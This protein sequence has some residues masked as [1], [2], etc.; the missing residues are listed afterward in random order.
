MGIP[1]LW[2][3]V[4][5]TAQ[6]MSFADLC[7]I[8]GFIQQT[9]STG[10]IIIGVDAGLW[11]AQSQSVFHKPQHSQMGQNPELRVLFYKLGA[12]N[13]VGCQALFVFDGPERP[14]VKR[15]KQVKAK[16]H[17]LV[18]E[19][20]Q[21]IELFGFHHHTA[22]G[23]ADAELAYLNRFGHIDAILSDDSDVTLF[24]GGRII[25]R[26]NRDE[27][28]VYTA[29]ALETGM[30]LTQGGLLLI[31]LF[32]GGD[33]NP[34]GIIGC[35][36]K[37]AYALARCGFGDALLASC[38]NDSVEDL[39]HFLVEWRKQVRTE[40][41]T[42]SR[43]YL[44]T[45]QPRLASLIPDS[46]PNVKTLKLYACPVTSWSP[47][48][49]IPPAATWVVQM[50]DVQGLAAFCTQKFGW[51]AVDLRNKYRRIVFPGAF[52]RR[53]TLASSFCTPKH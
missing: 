27:I 51:S 28:T 35:G 40:L 16:P 30:G 53:L 20:T 7:V 17:W 21:L 49:A 10:T 3:L 47:G 11:M 9:R 6:V 25:R 4:E 31:A 50:P 52:L 44:T 45:K 29:V 37:T 22:P 39:R 23:E 14:S 18:K 8:E 13:Q 43:G 24:G 46:F 12:L 15:N 36:I 34:G 42:N 41:R 26:F 33:Y 5:S 19:F 38:R 2:P 48:F 1:G 32:S